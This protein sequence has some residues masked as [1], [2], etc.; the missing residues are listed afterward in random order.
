MDQGSQ[1]FYHTV[2]DTH[3]GVWDAAQELRSMAL[4]STRYSA[5][6]CHIV[7]GI[8][9]LEKF[10]DNIAIPNYFE[11]SLCMSSVSGHKPREPSAT[12]PVFRVASNGIGPVK[13]AAWVWAQLRRH[14]FQRHA[15]QKR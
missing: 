12:V 14:D 10:Y 15:K 9:D 6:G 1:V 7:T 13:C 2:E 4:S 11:N 8:V 5:E 3:G